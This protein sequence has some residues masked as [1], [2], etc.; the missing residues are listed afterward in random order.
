M[1]FQQMV[2]ITDHTIILI[3]NYLKAP[4]LILKDT[5]KTYIHIIKIHIGRNKT[6]KMTR[7]HHQLLILSCYFYFEGSSDSMVSKH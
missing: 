5:V 2:Y 1:M 3:I 4:F 7:I 6:I